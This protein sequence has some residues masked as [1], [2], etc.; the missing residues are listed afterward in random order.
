MNFHCKFC[1][2]TGTT[3]ITARNHL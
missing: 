1:A 2:K 3:T